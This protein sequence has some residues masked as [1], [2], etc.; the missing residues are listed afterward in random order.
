MLYISLSHLVTILL[1]LSHSHAYPF[2]LLPLNTF[3]FHRLSPLVL[4]SLLHSYSH[5][6][7]LSLFL[8]LT[9]LPLSLPFLTLTF[10]HVHTLKFPLSPSLTFLPLFTLPL[11][12]TQHSS[13]SSYVSPP[14]P[15]IPT[16]IIPY[17][18]L[19]HLT[20]FSY[21]T[22]R[23]D[24][25]ACQFFTLLYPTLNLDYL[26]SLTFSTIT[27]AITTQLRFWVHRNPFK[28]HYYPLCSVTSCRIQTIL[29]C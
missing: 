15:I 7:I 10:P 3:P 26:A 21:N 1:A 23:D 5:V 16:T 12:L 4:F 25:F 13:T 19:H 18:M 17:S 9:L 28:L 8:S 6:P 27:Q 14:T 2:F 20:H 22:P 11:S 29:L 24:N